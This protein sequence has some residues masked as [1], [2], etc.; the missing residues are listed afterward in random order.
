MDGNIDESVETLIHKIKHYLITSMGKTLDEATDREFFLVL[1][2]ALREEIMINWTATK[3]TLAKKQVR[4]AYYLSMEYLPGRLLGNS[5]TNI[6][7]MEVVKHLLNRLNRKLEHMLV[8]EPEMGIGN[9]GLGRLA[10]CFL[11]SLA[12]QHY[13]AM[14][15][16][17]RYHYGI[18]EQQLWAGVQVER[19]D[20]WLLHENPWSFRRDAHAHTVQYGGRPIQTIT[21]SGD[22]TY[23]IADCDEVRALPYDFPIVG[24][25]TDQ[26]FSVV[27]L[28]LWSTKESPRN[29]QLQRYNSGHL[30]QAAENTALTD[31]LYPNDNNEMGKR[32]RLKQ[33]F[34]LV[35]ASLKDIV[36]QHLN[37]YKTIDNFGDKVR[38]QINDT[39][40]ALVV[41]ELIRILTHRFEVPWGEAMEMARAS[42]SYTN[43][44][45]LREAL[46][47]WNE[48]RLQNLL[49]RQYKV[50]ERLNAH[51]LKDVRTKFPGDEKRVQRMS[52][53][54]K[55]QVR[56]ANLAIYGAHSVNGVAALHTEILKNDI[57]K[58]FYEMY[59]ERFVNVTNGVTQR[60]WLLWSNPELAKWITSKIGDSWITHFEEI[61]KLAECASDRASQEEFLKIKQENK[62]EL[63]KLLKEQA[64]EHHCQTCEMA[65]NAF[66]D[67]NALFD[68]HIKRVH[69]YKRQMMNALHVLML[70]QEI[71][72]NPNSR[73]PRLVVFGGKAAPGYELAKNIIRFIYCLSRKICN[74]PRVN[75][76]LRLAYIENYNVSKAE[77]IIPAAD[78][79]EQIST[80][81]MEASGTGNMKLTMN[82]A[83]T[84]GTDDGANVEMREAVT[85]QWW[86]F[87]F[88]ASAE[89]NFKTQAERSYNPNQILSENPRIKQALESLRDHSLVEN[90]V[91]HEALLTLY[92][93]LTEG[94]N[95]SKPD[96]YLVLSDLE[97]YYQTHRKVEELYKDPHK[98]AEYAIHNI[99]GMGKF[100][101]DTSISNYATKIWN[102]EPCPP[103]PKELDCVREEYSEVQLCRIPPASA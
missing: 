1:G 34:L 73:I 4:K 44:T 82:G 90:D 93:S 42:I 63:I 85:D 43:H 55:G 21:Q 5:L 49:P 86:P 2:W 23:D 56:M 79:S 77:V 95:G 47:E 14:G 8:M 36:F 6:C 37:I 60:R 17:L 35:C 94:Y 67:H 84:I 9:G 33:E 66:L 31:V 92:K 10:S 69:E 20:C 70:Y 24:Y 38:I 16:G 28:R 97:D 48:S 52:M 89:E 75:D 98:W 12:S 13:P 88:G 87:K 83:L 57:F 18:F 61:S 11:D 29:F 50:I 96:P 22:T 58:D 51:F 72:D 103:D 74:D 30:D 3:H 45:V 54:E 41:A 59:P 99:A 81:G 65:E 91:E 100:S 7:H 53:I 101:T 102:I 39:H 76:H 25:G 64:M 27:T 71:R 78:L 40:P 26:D 32:V 19:P 15:Y 62:H 68:I 46:E 80:A